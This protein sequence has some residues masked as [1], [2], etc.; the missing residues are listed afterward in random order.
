MDVCGKPILNQT[1]TRPPW[2]KIWS[3]SNEFIGTSTRRV[4]GH[5]QQFSIRNKLKPTIMAK[6]S[7][8][9]NSAIRLK[10]RFY[11]INP[12]LVVNSWAAFV[13][14]AICH[15]RE[16]HASCWWGNQKSGIACPYCASTGGFELMG[17]DAPE[18]VCPPVVK[19]NNVI[20]NLEPDSRWKTSGFYFSTVYQ[21]E[22]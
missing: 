15:R 9:L 6:V 14:L 16:G 3:R 8:Y 18:G 11:F 4:A 5:T 20:I 2:W 1:E 12:F 22:V 19:G 10:R 21:P 13:A 7:T 17:S